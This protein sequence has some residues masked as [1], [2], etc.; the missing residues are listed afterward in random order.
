MDIPDLAK[1][2]LGGIFD[3]MD[4][5]IEETVISDASFE[6]SEPEQQLIGDYVN[7]LYSIA[8][9][10]NQSMKSISRLSES[11]LMTP[12]NKAIAEKYL[13]D[14]YSRAENS[15]LLGSKKGSDECEDDSIDNFS[16]FPTP[17]IVI[18]ED[19]TH[20]SV[21][22][23][24]LGI[25]QKGYEN[26]FFPA[27][28]LRNHLSEKARVLSAKGE[29]KKEEEKAKPIEE[30]K[31]VKEEKVEKVPK[32]PKAKLSEQDYFQILMK[33]SFP[34]QH[35]NE[36]EADESKNEGKEK[37]EKP[38][39]PL[40]AIKKQSSS[41]QPPLKPT[42]PLTLPKP[43]P[44]K[45]TPKKPLQAPVKN[46]LPPVKPP[47]TQKKTWV[48]NVPPTIGHGARTDVGSLPNYDEEKF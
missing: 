34:D 41:K 3:K 28:S 18:T 23:H 27:T 26:A 37:E 7:N 39:K 48:T 30:I 1:N 24:L 33:G 20:F 10:Q 14:V 9:R 8:E 2:F 11:I 45:K 35:E 32:K 36:K 25:Q 6:L 19:K 46:P 31:K 17:N 21:N 29:R 47:K 38:H 44:P 15:H 40:K 12:S 43:L 16:D 13:S 22:K 42:P 4:N 5:Y